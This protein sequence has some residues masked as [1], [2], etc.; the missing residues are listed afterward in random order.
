MTLSDWI[1]DDTSGV[2]KPCLISPLAAWYVQTLEDEGEKRL[3]QTLK[4]NLTK[5]TSSPEEAAKTMDSI[6]GQV[7]ETN[8]KLCNILTDLDKGMFSVTET[9]ETSQ[10]RGGENNG[11]A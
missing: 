1:Q 7:C 5:T 4:S 2:C 10:P 3:A 6:R 8:A 9:E 11:T